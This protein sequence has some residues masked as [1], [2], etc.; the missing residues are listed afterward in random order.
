MSVGVDDGTEVGMSDCVGRGTWGV[1]D[2]K[3]SASGVTAAVRSTKR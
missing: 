1:T 3:K 2:A